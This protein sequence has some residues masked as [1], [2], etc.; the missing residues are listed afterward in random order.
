MTDLK[1]TDTGPSWI[2]WSWVNPAD[3][4]FSHVMVYIND[5]FVTNTFDS[6]INSYNATGLSDGVTYTISIRTVNISGSISS[7]PTIDSATTIKLPS[8]YSLSGTNIT[9]SSITLIW[10]VS[11][12][13]TLVKILK[14]DVVLTNA[15]DS[16]LYVDTNLSSSTD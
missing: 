13:T 2:N 5:T 16:A 4:D 8:V 14:N 6:S 12:D 3:T 10:E 15:S 1:E 9:T 11:D 7:T